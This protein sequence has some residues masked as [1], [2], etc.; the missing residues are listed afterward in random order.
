MSKVD[1]SLVK[2]DSLLDALLATSERNEAFLQASPWGVLVVDDTFHI[3]F[4]N[5]ALEGMSGWKLEEVVGKHLHILIPPETRE[6]HKQHEKDYKKHPR[7]RHGDEP[8]R[9]EL[10]TRNNER[11]PVEISLSPVEMERG[12]FFFA[13]VRRRETLPS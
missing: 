10:L 4:M 13:S 8:F 5:R 1:N 9:P 7:T 6:I 12:E 3:V 11:V 2:I